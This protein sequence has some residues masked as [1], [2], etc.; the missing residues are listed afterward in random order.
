MPSNDMQ[1][2]ISVWEY[3]LPPHIRRRVGSGYSV[4]TA[5]EPMILGTAGE[6]IDRGSLCWYNEGDD[7]WYRATS[8]VDR[9]AMAVAAHTCGAG[10][11]IRLRTIGII[12]MQGSWDGWVT[13][14]DDGAIGTPGAEMVQIVGYACGGRI[15]VQIQPPY[16]REG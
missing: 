8:S 3:A 2:P 16:Y 15:V 4:D 5:S 7:R 6:A 14:G 12:D 10:E 13:L 9:P 11:V 1:R